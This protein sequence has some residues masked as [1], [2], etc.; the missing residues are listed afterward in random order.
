MFNHIEL[1]KEPISIY[2]KIPQYKAYCEMTEFEQSF[3]CGMLK[4]SNPKKV[5]EIGVSAGGTTAVI[6]NCLSL[7]NSDTKLY[8]IDLEEGYYRDAT[9][10]TGFV[11]EE[12]K[13]FLDKE[14]DHQ[15]YTGVYAPQV[16]EEI[17][18]GIDFL[19]IDTVHSLPGE[20]LDFLACFPYL[21]PNA[22]VVLHDVSLNVRLTSSEYATKLLF[23]TVVADK[24]IMEDNEK[25]AG[26][27]NIAA[28]SITEDTKKYIGNCFSALTITWSY[29]PSIREANLYREFLLKEYPKELVDIYDKAVIVQAYMACRKFKFEASYELFSDMLEKWKNAAHRI[30]YG[31]GF[32]GLWFEQLVK[33]LGYEAECFVLSDDRELPQKMDTELSICHISDLSFNP[34]E[35]FV[36]VTTE[37]RVQEEVITNLRRLGYDGV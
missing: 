34:K 21:A 27:P 17:G 10:P 15:V 23:D 22:T 19:I 6:L 32:W 8:S 31:C 30:I 37:K 36:V 5:V 20:M 1:Y 13:Q 29:M 28:F 4:K 3:L 16:L 26:F 11:A 2:D 35:C 24:F 14:V 7:V 33:C 18:R 25:I 9:K 12:A